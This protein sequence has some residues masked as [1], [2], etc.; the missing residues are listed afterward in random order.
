M[1][2]LAKTMLMKDIDGTSISLGQGRA[3]NV[4]LHEPCSSA[5]IRSMTMLPYCT[6]VKRI[7]SSSSLSVA[8]AYGLLIVLLTDDKKNEL[9]NQ[10]EKTK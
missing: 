1:E 9:K 8:S 10:K 3:D 4:W 2:W 7:R 6:S 5:R